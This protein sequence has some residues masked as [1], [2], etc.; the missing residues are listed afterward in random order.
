METQTAQMDQTSGLSTVARN[1]HQAPAADTSFSA[2]TESASTAYGAAT[3]AS[4]ATTTQM[5]PTA[6]S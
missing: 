1:R 2:A 4:T 6:V 5:K 3:E